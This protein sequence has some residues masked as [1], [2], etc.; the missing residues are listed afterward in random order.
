M[1]LHYIPVLHG[2]YSHRVYVLESDDMRCNKKAAQQLLE[3]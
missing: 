2:Y 1:I 3:T